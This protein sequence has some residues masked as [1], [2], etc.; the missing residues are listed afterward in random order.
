MMSAIQ[1]FMEAH[2][3]CVVL[4]QFLDR[5]LAGSQRQVLQDELEAA[6]EDLERKTQAV[7]GA[8]FAESKSVALD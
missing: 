3:Y 2:K 7:I 5:T 1:R 8:R 6:Y 4:E